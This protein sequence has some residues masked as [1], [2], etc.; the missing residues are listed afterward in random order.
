LSRQLL[1]SQ[2]Y[3]LWPV[4]SGNPFCFSIAEFQVVTGLPCAPLPEKYVS[5][6]F[7]FMNPAKDPCWKRII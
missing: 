4:V 6:D 1:C 7:K 2:Q 3:T 5:P